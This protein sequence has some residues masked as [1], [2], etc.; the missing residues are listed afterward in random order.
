MGVS[1]TSTTA[2]A[3]S[4]LSSA[5]SWVPGLDDRAFADVLSASQSPAEREER[6]AAFRRLAAAP[7]PHGK[8]EEWRRTDPGRFPFRSFERLPNLSRGRVEPHPWDNDFDVVVAVDG[9]MFGIFDIHSRVAKSEVVVM[10][11]ADAWS[12]GLATGSALKEWGER[13]DCPD[14]FTL[15]GE[16]FWNLGLYVE[17]KPGIRLEG[18]LLVRYHHRNAQ[19]LLMTRLLVCAGAGSAVRA[20][21]WHDAPS[22]AEV[23]TVAS[24]RWLIGEGAQLRWTTLRD[25]GPRA[26]HL[27]D[28][29]AT[30]RRDAKLEWVTLNLGGRLIKARFTGDAAAPGAA[31]ELDGLFFAHNQQHLDQKTL[32]VHSAPDTYSR[33]LY[34]GAVK[35]HA[36][37]I[38]QGQ[39]IAKP[40]AIRVDA[41]QK[42]NNLVLNDGAR[43]DSMPG[44]Q[45][46]ADDL[47]CSHGSTI[48]NLDQ[49]QLFYLRSRGIEERAARATLI[50]G[51]FEEVAQRIPYEH[52]RERLQQ[53]VDER[54]A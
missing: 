31:A 11:L 25:E 13:P 5:S 1:E 32:Q 41:Y 16:P 48:G 10:S 34:K 35:D 28:E 9:N 52:V 22:E 24:K 36:Y 26:I 15:V 45:I 27:A 14:Q 39:I 38:Y 20:V 40:G 12:R 47:K 17:V 42:N 50:R 6:L 3:G 33:L 53:R 37:S 49:E 30:L 43:A 18:G 46:D 23:M 4:E 19:S 51:F 7:L 8:M 54:L 21:E 2:S 29:W 44:L